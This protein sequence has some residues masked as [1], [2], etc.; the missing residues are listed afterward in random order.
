MSHVAAKKPKCD[1]E[2]NTEEQTLELIDGIQNEID[3][4]NEKASE[5]ILKVEQK[6]NKLRRPFFEK[7]N[8]VI[9]NIN[10]FW[11]TAFLNH[12]QVG[13]CD[14]KLNIIIL[15]EKSTKVESIYPENLLA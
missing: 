14:F 2:A 8:S 13:I 1:S 15:T 6:F 3:I 12:P 11:L 5:E 10:S 9:T 4:L 7:R